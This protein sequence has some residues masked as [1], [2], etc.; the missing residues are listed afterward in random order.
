[1][2][3]LFATAFDQVL[4]CPMAAFDACGHCRRHSER[5]VSLAKV[6]IREIER[7]RSLEI[8]KLFAESIREPG[9]PSAVHPH[10]VSLFLNV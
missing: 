8:L 6:V 5:T 1:M 2:Y 7:N 10:R 3:S 4:N 9:K